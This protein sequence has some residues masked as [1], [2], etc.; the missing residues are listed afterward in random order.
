MVGVP[1]TLTGAAMNAI[2][3]PY[4]AGLLAA[5]FAVCA[6]AA[7]G[8]YRIRARLNS[9]TGAVRNVW[10]VLCGIQAG[11]GLWGFDILASLAARTGLTTGYDPVGVIGSLMLAVVGCGLGFGMAWTGGEAVRRATG[12]VIVALTA[13]GVQGACVLSRHM[14]A[15]VHWEPIVIWASVVA[16]VV[17][18]AASVLAAGPAKRTV[19]QLVGAALLTASTV[20]AHAI[21]VA[22]LSFTPVRVE[23]LPAGLLDGTAMLL[24]ACLV[25]VLMIAAGLG[26]AYIDDNSSR[27]ALQ[28]MQRLANATREGIAVLGDDRRVLDCNAALAELFGGRSEDLVGRSLSDLVSLPDG[29]DGPRLD[30]RREGDL[31]AADG[32]RLPVAVT[33]HFVAEQGEDGRPGLIATFADLREQRAAEERIRFLNEHDGATG[34]PN[35]A[36]FLRQLH[37]ALPAT[38]AG[39]GPSLGLLM[40]RV[41][42]SQEVNAVHGHAA[43]DALLAKVGERLKRFAGE[44]GGVARLGGNEFGFHFPRAA[45]MAED[46]TDQALFAKF[47]RHMARPF[48]WRGQALEPRI[49]AGVACAPQDSSSVEELMTHADSALQAEEKDAINGVAYFRR[50]LHEASVAQRALAQDLKHAI[51]ADELSVHY[52]PQVRS[53]DGSLCGF[54]ALVRWTHPTLGFLP[55]DRFIG[56][57]EANGLI[58]AL[59]EWVLRRACLDAVSWPRPTPVAVNLS[60]LQVGEPGLPSRVHEILLETGLSPGR[61]ELEITESALFRDF[62]RALD[63][64]R[65]LK[66]LGVKI[67]M[68]DF[69]TGFSSLSTLQSFPFDKIKIDK[70]FVEG[71]GKLERSTVIVKAVLGIGRGLAIPVVAEGVETEEQMRFLRD[72]MCAS[73]QGYLIGKPGPVDLHRPLFFESSDRGRTSQAAAAA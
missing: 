34:L 51:A 30:A 62:Q 41:T 35:R 27:R 40:V 46:G 67:A 20:S 61:L 54:E 56:V 70:S 50:D 2:S 58:G 29:D 52:Q 37:E 22:G 10:L 59:G 47:S 36:A 21:A 49:R 33:L 28:R 15:V 26:A 1:A 64:L 19:S 73:V 13:A 12:G 72:E 4:D 3:L 60:P 39:E 6:A 42:N 9:A 63:T 43:G 65:R 11:A 8:V 32:A 25:S 48:V 45:E 31:L 14:P 71:V 17:L 53:E 38:L 5:A 55:P 23:H 44:V 57:A 69:G 24:L 16:G 68:D 18:A 66:A 7:G